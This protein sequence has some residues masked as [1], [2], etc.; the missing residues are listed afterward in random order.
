M[1]C[2][3]RPNPVEDLHGRED[4]SQYQLTQVRGQRDGDRLSATASFSD[5]KYVFLVDLNFAID[6]TAQWRFGG[7]Q[8]IGGAGRLRKGTVEAKS[9]MFLGGQNGPPSIGGTYDLLDENGA[10]EYRVTI[11]PTPLQVRVPGQKR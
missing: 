7:W 4:V 8:W 10:A 6:T 2:A 1:A 5:G 3:K 11:P 9:I